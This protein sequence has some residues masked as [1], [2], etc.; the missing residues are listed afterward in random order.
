MIFF[1]KILANIFRYFLQGLLIIAPIAITLYIIFQIFTS[2][3]S[4]LP[5]NTYTDAQGN[6][7]VRNYGLG[8]VL[9]VSVIIVIG[10]FGSFLLSSRVFNVFDTWLEKTPGVK[11][12]YSTTKDFFSAFAGNKKKFTKPVLAA[13]DNSE[14]YR[15][16]FITET[17]LSQFELIDYVAVY[18]PAAYSISGYVYL[19][20]KHR[21]K[22]LPNISA[23]D[24]MKF[25]ISGGVSDVD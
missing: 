16:G 17:Q 20:P 12:L 22:Q 2:I 10:Y 4:W 13:T 6:M 19:V 18:L 11:L 7:H 1:R 8:L 23:Q 5:L 3:D 24:A 15:V 14:V 21:I 25:A 9:I